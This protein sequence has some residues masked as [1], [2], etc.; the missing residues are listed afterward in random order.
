MTSK[1]TMANRPMFSKLSGTFRS[2]MEMM[3]MLPKIATRE[4]LWGD[5]VGSGG[6][7]DG[8]YR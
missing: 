2:D 8:V 7:A 5:V 3:E 1:E 4:E 6:M